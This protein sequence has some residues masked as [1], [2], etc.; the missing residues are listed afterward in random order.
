MEWWSQ[1]QDWFWSLREKYHVN[2]LA[3]EPQ[4]VGHSLISVAGQLIDW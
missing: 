3:P 4:L 1:V 2:L